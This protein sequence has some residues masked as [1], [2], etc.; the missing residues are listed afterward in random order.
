MKKIGGILVQ[1]VFIRAGRNDKIGGILVQRAKGI[2]SVQFLGKIRER[3]E[4]HWVKTRK[5]IPT[6]KKASPSN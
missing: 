6:V 5:N 1:T 2:H 3:N 4:K